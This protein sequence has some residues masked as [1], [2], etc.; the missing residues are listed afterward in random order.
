MSFSALQTQAEDTRQVRKS[1]KLLGFYADQDATVPDLETGF[2]DQTDRTKLNIDLAIWKPFGLLT[3]DGIERD[4][5]VDQEE[6]EAYNYADFVRTDILKAPKSL[7]VTLLQDKTKLA[8]EMQF[9]MDLS[10][11]VATSGKG[12]AFDEPSLPMFPYKRLLFIDLDFWSGDP[13]KPI[14]GID[15]YPRAK[16]S[17]IPKISKKKKGYPEQSVT[18]DIFT[19]TALGTPGRHWVDGA[20]YDMAQNGF[21][22]AA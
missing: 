13:T 11:I 16:Q 20:G 21:N 22:T 19:D 8:L 17:E 3:P 9:G 2:V 5:K 1:L 15:L 14:Y 6:A 12:L 4:S 7:T 18:F 10:G